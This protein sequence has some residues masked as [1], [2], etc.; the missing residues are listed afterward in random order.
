MNFIRVYFAKN[1]IFLGLLAGLIWWLFTP[2]FS[3]FQTNVIINSTILG[4]L[5]IGI[6]YT[7]YQ[8]FLLQRDQRWFLFFEQ[9][10]ERFPGISNP[11]ILAPLNAFATDKEANL[12]VF[13]RQ[14]LLNSIDARLDELRGLNR[15]LIGLLIF[16]GLLGTFWGLSQT[17]GAIA[18]VISSIDGGGTDIKEAFQ[19]LRQGLQSPLQGMGTAFSSS[20]FGLAS[21]L[22]LGFLDLQVGRAS[23]RFYQWLEEKMLLLSQQQVDSSPPSSYGA[24][25]SQG[26]MEQTAENLNA[27]VQA[28]QHHH[29]NR[30]SVVKSVQHLT[31]K[32]ANLAEVLVS[33][34]K[35]LE[36]MRQNNEQIHEMLKYMASQSG[37]IDMVKMSE[38]LITHLASVDSNVGQLLEDSIQGRQQLTHEIRAEIR[39]VAKTIS[40]LADGQEEAA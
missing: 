9:G 27:V 20:M 4:T 19:T 40:A 16:L 39:L 31:D 28:L 36:Y 30:L 32:L 10:R 1:I 23:Q 37:A 21:S 2:L 33:Q 38:K 15:Y 6:S 11:V 24:A 34:K 12:N 35:Q 18:G 7:F 17:I 25:Y 22:I 3:I 13:N 29:D 14:S 5:L 26:I 8:L